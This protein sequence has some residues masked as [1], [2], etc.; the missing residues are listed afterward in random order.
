MHG[1]RNIKICRKCVQD[2]T[3][4]VR[5]LSYSPCCIII[6]EC[7]QCSLYISHYFLT[8]FGE[9]CVATVSPVFSAQLYFLYSTSSMSFLLHLS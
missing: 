8:V 5:S 6:R 7:V 9:E 3:H 4:Q 2:V 1:Q